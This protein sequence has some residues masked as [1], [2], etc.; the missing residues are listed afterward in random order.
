ML[1]GIVI[2]AAVAGLAMGLMHVL[3]ERRTAVAGRAPGG[4]RAGGPGGR[5][6]NTAC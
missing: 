3:V 4:V 1:F 5:R 2:L 6:A